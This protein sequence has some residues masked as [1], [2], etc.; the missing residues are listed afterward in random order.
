MQ[1]GHCLYALEWSPDS[2]AVVVGAGRDLAVKGVQAS[3]RC[4]HTCKSGGN[5]SLERRVCAHGRD[6]LEPHDRGI[7][8]RVLLRF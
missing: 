5:G 4:A 7:A 6:V 2:E 8:L 3:Q 1:M